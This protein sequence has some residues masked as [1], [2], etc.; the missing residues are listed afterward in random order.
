ME[1]IPCEEC[2]RFDEYR[3]SAHRSWLTQRTVN[4]SQGLR[5]KEAK[6]VLDSLWRAYEL[7]E[8]ECVSHYSQ[9]HP[10]KGLHPTA[11]QIKL[12]LEGRTP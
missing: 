4:L 11:K 7:A 2:K 12:L 6:Q 10:E 8:A 3:T 5:G 9:K 1:K